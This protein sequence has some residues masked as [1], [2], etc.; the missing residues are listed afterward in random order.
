MRPSCQFNSKK[1]SHTIRRHTCCSL[2]GSQEAFEASHIFEKFGQS[3]LAAETAYH[4]QK[5]EP[6][7]ELPIHGCDD[8]HSHERAASALGHSHERAAS[9]LSIH[10]SALRARLDTHTSALRARSPSTRARCERALHWDS[11]RAI[12]PTP[13]CFCWN[14]LGNHTVSLAKDYRGH[15]GTR[16]QATR[17]HGARAKPSR[18]QRDWTWPRTIDSVDA[19]SHKCIFFTGLR[20]TWAELGEAIV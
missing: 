19:V 11:G 9:A 4:W 12:S 14:M 1:F 10:T 8:S 20:L 3:L 18:I 2:L 15:A 6:N 16:H 17:C 5:I 7:R 13:W